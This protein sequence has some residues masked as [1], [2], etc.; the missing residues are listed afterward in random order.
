MTYLGTG[1]HKLE[2]DLSSVRSSTWIT[3][4]S[5]H[6]N[7][8]HMYTIPIDNIACDYLVIDTFMSSS[9]QQSPSGSCSDLHPPAPLSALSQKAPDTFPSSMLD[10]DRHPLP[11]ANSTVTPR[12]PLAGHPSTLSTVPA[13]AR[14]LH[15]QSLPCRS[16][17]AS[18][19]DHRA[20]Y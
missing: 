13:W 14:T 1:N 11:L 2:S 17:V 5:N 4:S 19:A 3:T 12:T 16:P 9:F 18:S 8:A 7:L 15:G 6:K 10:W 20:N